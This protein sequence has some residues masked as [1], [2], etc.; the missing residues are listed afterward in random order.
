[1]NAPHVIEKLPLWAGGDL[2]EREAAQVQA[3]L[4]ACPAC[5]TE[6][7][8]YQEAMSLLK[9]PVE[10][11]FTASERA[12]VRNSVMAEIR[13]ANKTAQKPKRAMPWLPP[14]LIAAAAS[15]PLFMLYGPKGGGANNVAGKDVKEIE[16]A[17][18]TNT[19]LSSSEAQPQ[20]QIQANTA[21]AGAAQL[22]QQPKQPPLVAKT[23]RPAQR[24]QQ[25]YAHA[26]SHPEGLSHDSSITRIEFYPENPN[27]KIIWFINS[28]TSTTPTTNISGGTNEQPA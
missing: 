24:H 20:S 27:I 21:Q 18:L 2:S 16:T 28:N 6:A 5:K 22:K 10:P 3:H 12:G 15:V 25:Y 11:P 26:K 8:A 9:E 7:L 4:D 23:A 14:L 1:M 13:A 19:E 17:R